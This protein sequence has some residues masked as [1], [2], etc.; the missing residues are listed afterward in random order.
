M[1]MLLVTLIAAG[2]AWGA[3]SAS[4]ERGR[5]EEK[6]SCLACHGARII[7]SQRLSRAVWGR[8][9]DKMARWGSEVKDREALLD[10]LT[11]NYGDD[12]PVPEPPRSGDGTASRR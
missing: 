12:K 10:Y 5:A 8:E 1:R 7:H 9:L 4:I 3:D 2:C 11:A 6:R